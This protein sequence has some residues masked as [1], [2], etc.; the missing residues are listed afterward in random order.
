MVDET[1]T[2][3]GATQYQGPRCDCCGVYA[4]Y[5]QDHLDGELNVTVTDDLPSVKEEYGIP[6]DLRSCHTV[7]LGATSWKGICQ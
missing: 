6:V 5:L 4:D 3:A 7:V 2:V 1:L